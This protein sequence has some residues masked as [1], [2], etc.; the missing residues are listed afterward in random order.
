MDRADTMF[1]KA[2]RLRDGRC[3]SCGKPAYEN[4]DGDKILGI[5]CSH[6]F[7]RAK[8]SVRFDPKNADSLCPERCHPYYE[9]HKDEYREFKMR[10]LGPQRF[11][12]L[13]AKSEIILDRVD[14]EGEYKKAKRL[15]YKIKDRH[16]RRGF[17]RN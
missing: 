8:E 17:I 6:F 11:K 7:I 1:S 3:L 12:L 9:A 5:E 16:N 13:A 10:Q 14:R 4:N 2:I 15:W